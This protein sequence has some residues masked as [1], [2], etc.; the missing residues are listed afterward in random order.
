MLFKVESSNISMVDYE[1]QDL[2][3]TVYF[4]NGSVYNYYPIYEHQVLEF[5]SSASKGKWFNKNI[6]GNKSLGGKKIK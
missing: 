3:L 6:R 5:S 2:T 1:P 4:N